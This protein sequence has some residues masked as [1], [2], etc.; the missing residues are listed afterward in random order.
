[1]FHVGVGGRG[2]GV[3]VHL[4]DLVSKVHRLRWVR[5]LLFHVGVGGRGG[6]FVNVWRWI[7]LFHCHVYAA[8]E[9]VLDISIG[10]FLPFENRLWID[11]MVGSG[12]WDGTNS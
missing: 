9:V 8:I 7:V 3:V 10:I 11:C 12:G 5:V 4:W 1:M 2:R 6:A